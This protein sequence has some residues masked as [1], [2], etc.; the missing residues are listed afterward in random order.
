MSPIFLRYLSNILDISE[1]LEA[2]LAVKTHRVQ[3]YKGQILLHTGQRC[4][5]LYF[6]ESGTLR[7]YYVEGGREITHSFSEKME[8][9]TCYYSFIA[10]KPSYENIQALEDSTLIQIS[11][12]D[13]QQLYLKFPETERLGRII[14]ENYYIQLE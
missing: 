10:L 3:T 4:Q 14:T 5:D 8:F 2:E 7:G 1:E 11:Y 13:L 12:S 9:V 6:V